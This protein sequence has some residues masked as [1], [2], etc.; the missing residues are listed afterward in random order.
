MPGLWVLIPVKPFGEG[1]SRLAPQ[2]SRAERAELSRVLLLRLLAAVA[3]AALFDGCVV[4]SRDAAVLTMAAESGA[5]PLAEVAHDLNG[6][7]EQGRAFAQAEGAGSLLVLPADL[8]LV[9]GAALLDIVSAF[10]A[11]HTGDGAAVLVAPSSS[12]GTNALLQRPVDAIPFAFGIE[13]AARHMA[14]AQARGIHA[15]AM[16]HPSLALDVDFPTD[17]PAHLPGAAPTAPPE[18]TGAVAKPGARHPSART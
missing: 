1:K 11:H 6:A 15:D 9:D 12:G 8:P 17:L 7:L 5:L 13:S 18:A 10:V 2:L 16:Q 3:D 14:L 4:V